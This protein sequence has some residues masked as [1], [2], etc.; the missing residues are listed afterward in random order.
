VILVVPVPD[1]RL[2]RGLPAASLEMRLEGTDPQWRVERL[3]PR[4]AK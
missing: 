1:P 4:L 3:I 2:G